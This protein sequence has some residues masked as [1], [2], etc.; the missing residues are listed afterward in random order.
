M[1]CSRKK[2][3][4]RKSIFHSLETRQKK[5]KEYLFLDFYKCGK[6]LLFIIF[7]SVSH[8]L[9]SVEF[10]WIRKEL[11]LPHNKNT[12]IFIIISVR[13]SVLLHKI[14]KIVMLAPFIFWQ[15]GNLIRAWLLNIEFTFVE[16][17]KSPIFNRLFTYLS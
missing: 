17:L 2:N 5:Q 7:L 3:R 15:I 10:A 1:Q 6:F 11:K 16:A 13:G 9:H 4:K 12:N 14:I 8:I